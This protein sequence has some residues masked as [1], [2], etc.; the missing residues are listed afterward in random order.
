MPRRGK[1]KTIARAIYEDKSGRAGVYRD[2]SGRPR[3]IRFPPHTPVAEIRGRLNEEISKHKGSGRAV[4]TRGTLSAAIDEWASQEQHLAS[5]KERRAELRAWRDLYGPKRL[6]A[7][8]AKDVRDAMGIWTQNKVAPKTIRNRLWTLKHLYHVLHGPTVSTPV[9]DVTPPAK[10]RQI[11][12]PTS[13]DIILAVYQKLLAFEQPANGK[14]PRLLDAKTRARFMVRASTGRRPVEI[15]R[16]LP[17]DVD[18]ERRIWRVRDAK[19]GWS[20]GLYLNEDMLIAWRT[21]IDADAWGE[22]NT[23]SMAEVLRAAGWPSDRDAVTKRYHSR[24]YNLRHSVGI[25]LS[26]RGVDLADVGGWLGQTDIRTTRNAYVPILKSRM[27]RSAEALEGRLAGW[28]VPSS[29]PSSGDPPRSKVLLN[30]GRRHGSAGEGKR[31]KSA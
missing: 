22:F 3:E 16:A 9:D 15:M 23:G 19:G 7:I 1:R 25:E 4:S 21:F 2:S 11:I 31:K 17:G 5:W 12:N 29:V 6:R 13:A 18:L 8:T 26:E 14:R 24:P 10:V 28:Q 27:Q 30:K 20:E